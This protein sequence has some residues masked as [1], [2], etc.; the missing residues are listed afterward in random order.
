[1]LGK[2]KLKSKALKKKQKKKMSVKKIR[3]M[4]R[5]KRAQRRAGFDI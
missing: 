5:T 3:Q 2:N 1:M 4:A